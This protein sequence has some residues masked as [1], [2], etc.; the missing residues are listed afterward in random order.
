MLQK[1]MISQ[2]HVFIS[3]RIACRMPARSD[4]LAQCT[5]SLP[6]PGL[7]DLSGPPRLPHRTNQAVFYSQMICR[8][9]TEPGMAPLARHSR[10]Q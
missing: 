7:A 5:T 8:W 9:V 1:A 6:M 2:S 3:C 10:L 4:R